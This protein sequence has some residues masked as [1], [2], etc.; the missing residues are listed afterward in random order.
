ME[1]SGGGL[2]G[3]RTLWISSQAQGQSGLQILPRKQKAI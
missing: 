3:G 1:A 2:G